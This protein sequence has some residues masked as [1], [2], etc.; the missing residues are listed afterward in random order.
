MTLYVALIDKTR[1][2][3]IMGNYNPQPFY[4][5]DIMHERLEEYS[6][7][8]IK[9]FALSKSPRIVMVIV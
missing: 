1:I 2:L 9:I 8:Y 5:I 3:P 6:F 7:D 4:N